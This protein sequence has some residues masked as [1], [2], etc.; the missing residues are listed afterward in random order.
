MGQGEQMAKTQYVKCGLASG[1]FDEEVYVLLGSS[2]AIVSR[3]EVRIIAEPKPNVQGKG[4]VCVYVVERTP[5]RLL[6]ELPGQPVVGGLR[7]WV[8][9]ADLSAA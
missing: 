5:D 7:T 4:E 3:N 1:F 9:M 6:V 2:S 8:P